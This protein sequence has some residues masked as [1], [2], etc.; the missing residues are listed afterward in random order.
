MNNVTLWYCESTWTRT[1]FR[2]GL[3]KT[4]RCYNFRYSRLRMRITFS[5]WKHVENI[6]IKSKLFPF[7]SI[8]S[9]TVCST[10]ILGLRKMID[11]NPIRNASG[12]VIQHDGINPTRNISFAPITSGWIETIKLTGSVTHFTIL[13]PT[14]LV[15]RFLL[16]QF[17][18]QIWCNKIHDWLWFPVA[19]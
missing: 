6:Y 10:T 19:S 14:Q 12:S 13:F 4:K 2:P 16:Q 17:S 3:K 11:T 18:Y 5:P 9:R 7:P 1:M 15:Y 8:S